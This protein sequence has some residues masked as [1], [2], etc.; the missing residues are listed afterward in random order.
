MKQFSEHISIVEL[1]VTELCTRKCSFCPRYDSKI[2]PNQNKH[3]CRETFNSVIDSLQKSNYNGD[4]C[5]SGF[6]E[7]LMCKYIMYGLELLSK[8]Y[9]TTLITNY[10]LL[11]IDKLKILDSFKLKAIWIDLYDNESQYERLLEL[12]K[13][14]EYSS[15]NLTIKKVYSQETLEFYNRGGTSTFES[16]AGIDTNRQC[17]IPFY[18]VMIDWNG[19]Y[20]LCHSDW[21]R[22]SEISK[23]G[24]NVKNITLEQYLNC[25]VYKRFVNKMLKTQRNGLNPCE[26]CDIYGLKKGK[27]WS[28]NET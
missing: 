14:S 24:L 18:K 7:P 20:L 21:H 16:S 11:T 27:L 5:V 4:I 6:S 22:E 3:M 2:Y 10:D 23:S 25:D 26:K 12:L 9:P 1:N 17:H 8:N 13:E 15:D 28:H 19:N